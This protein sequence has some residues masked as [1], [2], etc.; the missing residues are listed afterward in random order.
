MRD[1]CAT[2]MKLRIALFVLIASSYALAADKS[3]QNG[4]GGYKLPVAEGFAI[5]VGPTN[6][7]QCRVELRSDAGESL[8]SSG[9]TESHIEFSVTG[10]D[11]NS[12]G[13][14]DAVVETTVN[15][16]HR[17]AV[18]TP[19]NTPTLV[20][21]IVTNEP[22]TFEDRLGDGKVELYG[23]EQVFVGI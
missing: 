12:D 5:Q 8:Y 22:L 14:N 6:A 23:H 4:R 21:E 13:K 20:R 10:R 9:G 17:Y 1:D 3:C 7:G 2:P 19:G 18:L 11:V 15:G 16:K